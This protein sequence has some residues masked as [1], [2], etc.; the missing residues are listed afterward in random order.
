MGNHAV[1]QRG[2]DIIVS[3]GAG[4]L[5]SFLEENPGL[6]LLAI[7]GDFYKFPE[8]CHF[9][10]VQPKGQFAFGQPFTRVTVRLPNPV[11]P[12][13]DRSSAVLLWRDDSFERSIRQRMVLNAYGHALDARAVARTIL[14]GL[15]HQ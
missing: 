4:K 5:V 3:L 1:R 8:S 14:H 10:A 2:H 11:V 7:F 15:L 12:D 9:L 6:L 13:D